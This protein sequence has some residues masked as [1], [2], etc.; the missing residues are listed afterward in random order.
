MMQ[1]STILRGRPMGRR[2]CLRLTLSP[3]SRGSTQLAETVPICENSVRF[4]AITDIPWSPNGMTILLSGGSGPAIFLFDPITET[5]WNLTEPVSWGDH[6][7][8]WSP[9]GARVVFMSGMDGDENIYLMDVDGSG[10]MRLTDSPALD[11][12]PVWSPI[13]PDRV[14]AALTNRPPVADAGP[15]QTVTV[16]QLVLLE[17]SRSSDPDGDELTYRWRIP[18]GD[19]TNAIIRGERV[20]YTFETPGSY[21]VTL[22]VFDGQTAS[23]LDEAAVTVVAATTTGDASI[24]GSIEE[25]IGDAVVTGEIGEMTGDAIVT[26]EIEEGTGDAT[27]TGTIED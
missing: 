6:H 18:T 5:A 1:M 16:G 20:E 2:F 26:G 25:S 8:A 4:Q 24:V 14:I 21:I 12:E 9:D 10:L 7:P 22:E 27:I 19:G 11:N 13:L 15:D 3:E 17:G 23:E